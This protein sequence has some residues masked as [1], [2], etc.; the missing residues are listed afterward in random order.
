M[1]AHDCVTVLSLSRCSRLA[2]SFLRQT[3]VTALRAQDVYLRPVCNGH[4]VNYARRLVADVWEE[5]M[6]AWPRNI[7]TIR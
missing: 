3:P 1:G 7:P 2:L 5:G 6:S 4:A